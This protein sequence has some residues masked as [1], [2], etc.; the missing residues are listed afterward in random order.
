MKIL[1]IS[2]LV[3]MGLN[4]SSEAQNAQIEK[5]LH[6]L[7]A[8]NPSQRDEFLNKHP[9]VREFVS[10]HP[11]AIK[12]NAESL[13]NGIEH[14]IN[15]KSQYGITIS[16][17]HL[18][19]DGSIWIPRGMGLGAFTYA[20][21]F[22]NPNNQKQDGNGGF[23]GAAKNFG[24]DILNTSKSWKIDSVR[25][26]VSQPALD[27]K[28]D[29]YSKAYLDNL[30]NGVNLCI[31][32]GLCVLISMQDEKHSGETE[33]KPLP[34]EET[35]RAWEVIGPIF[36]NNPYVMY[37][38]FNECGKPV[39]G[40]DADNRLNKRKITNIKEDPN[41]LP[42]INPKNWDLWLNGGLHGK[43][44]FIGHQEIVNNFRSKGWNNVIIADGIGWARFIGQDAL[45]LKDPIGRLAFGV[46][47]YF[48]EFCNSP[49]KWDKAFGNI[50][51]VAP[52]LVTEWFE[53]SSVP[54]GV[55]S[56]QIPLWCSE[57]LSYIKQHNIPMWSFA[58]DIPTTIV[59]D[60][61]GTPNNWDNFNPNG[62]RLG[63]SGAGCGKM[64]LEYFLSL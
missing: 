55:K 22:S 5:S 29:M 35:L 45:K 57:F 12:I 27:P 51:K 20:P 49:E 33:C 19:K 1:I 44:T 59:I 64:V 24:Q 37:E 23:V 47:P 18:L 48:T 63:D 41:D 31:S 2:L 8:M 42:Q 28:S 60:H 21:Y 53:N 6:I 56:Y 46:H 32:N 61:K 38:I 58:L 17:T 25:F 16:G 62:I 50:S 15:T 36:A 40:L 13:G 30:V 52:V 10:E 26:L 3:A 9:R 43:N 39:K 11:D 54:F 4:C 7:D 14:A 34:T